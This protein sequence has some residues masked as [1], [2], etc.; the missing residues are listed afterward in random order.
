MCRSSKKTLRGSFYQVSLAAGSYRRELLGLVAIHTLIHA[1]T[2]YYQPEHVLG[3]ICCNNMSALNQ[4]GKVR[5]RVQSSIK[6]LNLQQALRTYKCKVNMALIYS[7]IRAH[8]DA[9]KP[10]SMLTLEEQL[11]VI[12]DKLAKAAVQRYLSD[13]TPV[14][15]RIQLLC[16]KRWQS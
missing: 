4:A 12:C 15:R 7:H 2:E 6:H 11:N 13:A 16:W 5:K 8:Q 14:G 1:A 10:W 9:L 3:K